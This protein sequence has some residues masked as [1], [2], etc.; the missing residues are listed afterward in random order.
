VNP[1]AG[2]KDDPGAASAIAHTHLE[3]AFGYGGDGSIED[4]AMCLKDAAYVRVS[5]F[6]M[7]L[8]GGSWAG[9]FVVPDAVSFQGSKDH[10][11]RTTIKFCVLLL[12]RPIDAKNISYRP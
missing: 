1:N 10:S 9:T 3:A 6:H 11:D 2:M 7:A 8:D 4:F 5:D 12:V